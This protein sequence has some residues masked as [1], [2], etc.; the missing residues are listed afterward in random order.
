MASQDD[1]DFEVHD[2]E[3]GL[4]MRVY[5]KDSTLEKLDGREQLSVGYHVENAAVRSDGVRLIK[6]AVLIEISAC[7]V[8]AVTQTW[9][10]IRDSDSVGTLANE[11]KNFASEGAALGFTRA[12]Q[13]LMDA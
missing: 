12:L 4:A 6:S 9:C 8:G 10:E 13:R 1:G 11:A 7:Y 2:C 3:A 5:L